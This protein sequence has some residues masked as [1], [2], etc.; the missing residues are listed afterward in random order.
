MFLIDQYCKYD[1]FGLTDLESIGWAKFYVVSGEYPTNSTSGP[2]EASHPMEASCLSATGWHK[3]GLH[4]GP[5]GGLC[6]LASSEHTLYPITLL[7]DLM[8]HFTDSCLQQ[9]TWFLH[10]ASSCC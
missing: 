1:G 3:S 6:R 2:P 9:P 4:G 5:P 7:Y 10:S 8:F